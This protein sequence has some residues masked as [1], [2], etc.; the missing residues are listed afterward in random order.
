MDNNDYIYKSHSDKKH[1]YM[2]GNCLIEFLIDYE[3]NNICI[4]TI[5]MLQCKYYVT[6]IVEEVNC[7]E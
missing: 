3:I 7:G 1:H 6:Q 2:Y 4:V 5:F